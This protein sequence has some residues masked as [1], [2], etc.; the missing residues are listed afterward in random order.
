[1]VIAHY[2]VEHISVQGEIYMDKIMMW[3]MAICALIGGTDRL[4]GN[5]L[6]LGKRFEDGFQLFGPTALSM[7]G[8]IC[9]TPLVSLGLE[10][11]IVPFYRMLHLDPGMLGGILALDMGGYQLCKELALDPAIGRY[12]GIIVGATLGCTITFTIPV[13]M[14]KGILAGLSALPVGILVGGLL[15]G[16]SIEKLLIQSLPVFLLAVLLILGLSRFPDGMIRGFRV[17]AEIIRG[18]GTIGIALGAFSYMTGVQLLPEMAGLDEALGVVSSI[19]IVLL[20]SL[21]FAEI[22]QRLLKKPLEWVGEKIGLGRLGTAGLLVGI[23]SALP[24]I[25]DMKQMNEREIVMNAALLVCGTSMV[26]AHLGFVLGVDAP[27]TGAL[28]AGKLTG[29]IA[30]VWMA[31]QIMKKTE[32]SRDR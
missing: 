3:I 16:L 4:L 22:L 18:A 11:T 9:I 1:M 31:W 24:V 5:R 2:C 32:S 25:A 26:A 30:G 7:A 20:G 19:G 17:F 6:G 13:G 14:A 23:V 28:L 21:P 29:G 10:Y 27:A 12:G 15:C 8:L